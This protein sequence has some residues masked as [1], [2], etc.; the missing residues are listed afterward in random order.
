MAKKEYWFSFKVETDSP[1]HTYAAKRIYWQH[2]SDEEWKHRKEELG[3]E[4]S[5]KDKFDAQNKPKK[6]PSKKSEK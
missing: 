4:E 5:T 1:T 2:L 3:A 6:K